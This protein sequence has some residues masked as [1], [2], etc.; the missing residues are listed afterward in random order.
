M[1]WRWAEHTGELELE[2]QADSEE[3]VFAEALAAVRELLGGARGEP[4]ERQ[5]ELSAGD[6]GALLADWVAELAYLAESDGLVPERLELLELGA[7]RLRARVEGRRGEPPH[8]VKA[9][10]YHRLRFER[11]DGWSARVVLD[12]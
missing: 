11:S 5:V 12:V 4:I 9:A 8:L 2:L 6:R 1:A 7:D 10:T 3:A